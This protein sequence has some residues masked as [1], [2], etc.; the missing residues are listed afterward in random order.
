MS[1]ILMYSFASGIDSQPAIGPL[2]LQHTQ[3]WSIPLLAP[4]SD[5]NAC[6]NVSSLASSSNGVR[7]PNAPPL[8]ATYLLSQ[9]REGF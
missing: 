2:R 4:S 6:I 5:K 8:C 7:T 3:S 1:T 9:L